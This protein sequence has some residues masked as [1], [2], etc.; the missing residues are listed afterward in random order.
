MRAALP[1]AEVAE[2]LEAFLATGPQVV[3]E[4]AGHGA[5]AEHGTAIL[6]RGIDLVVASVGALADA[7]LFDAL[8]AAAQRGGAQLVVPSG[9]IGGID[10]VAAARLAG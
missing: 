10:I 3:A 7:A 8:K 9:A 4:C 1:D 6:G 5:V 2:T